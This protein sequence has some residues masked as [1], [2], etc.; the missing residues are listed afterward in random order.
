MI[1]NYISQEDIIIKT[2]QNLSSE[3]QQEVID[4]A[5]F[6]ES[7]RE[8]KSDNEDKNKEVSAYEVAKEF[9]GCV[10]FG[11][12]DLATNKDYLQGLGKK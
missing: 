7:K 11:N 2:F 6:L 10:D 9:A 5:Q 3:K 4:F 8:E 1:K 12:G